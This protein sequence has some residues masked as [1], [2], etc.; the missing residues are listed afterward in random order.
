MLKSRKLLMS[1]EQHWIKQTRIVLGIVSYAIRKNT[2]K[3]KTLRKRKAKVE[4]IK[5][6][7]KKMKWISVPFEKKKRK[8]KK[9]IVKSKP[10]K[11]KM[12]VNLRKY[13]PWIQEKQMNVPL[14]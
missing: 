11:P 7:A 13:I 8:K 3:P 2:I 6:G 14:W 5:K 9:R 4:Q 10:L 12:H 1:R